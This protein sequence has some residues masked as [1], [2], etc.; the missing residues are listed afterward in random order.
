VVLGLWGLVVFWFWGCFVRLIV[1]TSGGSGLQQQQQQQQLFFFAVDLSSL[2][3]K[4]AF[5]GCLN[6]HQKGTVAAFNNRAT[7][8]HK[9]ASGKHLKPFSENPPT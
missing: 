1:A 5:A 4:G 6:D 9:Q 7:S 3:L 8:K 2:F